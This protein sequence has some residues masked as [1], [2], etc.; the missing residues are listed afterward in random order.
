MTN[1][2]H[3]SSSTRVRRS[4]SRLD[5]DQNIL[6][7]RDGLQECENMAV[8]VMA[9]KQDLGA[10]V[11][12]VE[13]QKTDNW[14]LTA[15][16]IS[17]SYGQKL[18]IITD[19]E[20]STSKRARQEYAMDPHY[21]VIVHVECLNN[22]SCV[23]KVDRNTVV[24]IFGHV[25]EDGQTVSGL[26]GSSLADLI[27]KPGLEAAA[28]FS[29]D[30]NTTTELQH[31]FVRVLMVRGSKA[32]LETVQDHHQIYKIMEQSDSVSTYKI[33]ERPADHSTQY[34]HQQIVM[35]Q[36]NPV[37]RTAAES[38]YEKHPTVSS[39]YVLGNN[40]KPR[41]IRGEPV[42]LS[43]NSR[44]VLV[45]HGARDQSGEMKLA[46]LKSPE[47]AKIIQNTHKVSNKIKT[48]SVVA[49]DVGSDESFVE[50]LAKELHQ[51]GIETELHLRNSLV[52]VRHTGEKITQEF[53]VDGERWR[54]NDDS[55][56]VVATIDKNGDVII[57]SEA[58]SKGEAVF[59]NE[60]NFLG[61]KNIPGKQKGKSSQ[62]PE[63]PGRFIGEDV[64]SK[65]D[66]NNPDQVKSACDELEAMTWGLFYPKRDKPA[67]VDIN[68]NEHPEE[69]YV[70][71]K[72]VVNEMAEINEAEDIKE[73]LQ[74]CYEI[75]SGKDALR[76]I[77]HY[78]KTGETDIT[79]LKIGDW[80]FDVD[81]KTLYMIPAGKKL[82]NT[83]DKEEQRKTKEWIIEQ[84]GE[85]KEKYS[86]IQ[87]S[88]QNK[89]EYAD[90]VR[91]IFKGN[92]ISQNLS[93]DKA[94]FYASYF[95]AS[96]I[97][98][99]AR[100]FRTFPLT[101]M[102]LDL[103][104]SRPNDESV[105]NFL[106]ENHPMARQDSWTN[107][108]HRGFSGTAA[109]P[110]AHP[111]YE[112]KSKILKEVISLEF[113]LFTKWEQTVSDKDLL[114][115]FSDLVA[116]YI[117]ENVKPLK[118]NYQKFKDTLQD[119]SS[120]IP[121][122]EGEP[123]ASG[124]LSGHDD[125]YVTQRDVISASELENSFIHEAYFSRGSALLAEEIHTQVTKQFG[126][127]LAGMHVKKGSNRIENGEFI[128]Q[129]ESQF[130]DVE[131]VEFRT[132]LS[133][134]TQEFYK[135]LQENMDRSV[136][137]MEE[138]SLTSSHQGSKQVERV[139][140]AVGVL[141]LLLGMKG[142]IRAFEQGHVKDGVVG[143]LQ[144]AHGTAAIASSAIARTALSS[145]GRAAKAAVTIMRSPAMK[146]TM[147]AIPIMGIGIGVY[148]AVEDFKRHD[149]LG[150]IDGA[151]DIGMIALDVVELAQPELAPFIA[152]INV[153]LSV[154][155]MVVD[156]IYMGIKNELDSLP[157]DA[158]V[159][160]KI[161]A[162]FVGFGKGVFHFIIHVASLFYDWHYDEIEEGRRLVA[163]IS[164][165]RKYY[166]VTKETDGVTAIDFS[167][168]ASSWNGGG[169]DFCLADSGQSQLCMDYF[170]SSDESFGRLCWDIDAQGSTDIILGTGESHELE[171]TTLQ[172]K[173][174]LFIP[175]GSVTV[176]SGYK[177]AS[178]SRYG[179]YRGNR[180]SNRFF[181]VQNAGDTHMI[182]V[183]LSYY[184]KLYGE[185][186]DDKFFL[187]PQRTYVE[188]SG[189]KDTYLIPENGG[190]TIINNFDPSKAMDTLHFSVDYRD[191]SVSKSGD[192]VVLMYKSTHSVTIKNWFLGEL[193]RHMI[194]MSGDG[195]LFEI[196][197]TVVT[198]VQ[199]VATGINKMFQKLGETINAAD[200]LLRKVIGIVG[201]QSD[202]IIAGN[203]QNNLI[204]GGGGTDRLSGG[205]GED[206]YNIKGNSQSVLIENFSR[207]RKT[208]LAIIEANLHSFSLWVEG[209]DVKL[210]ADHDN[211]PIYVTLVNWFRSQEDRH[212]VIV[213][214]DLITFT[215]SD[216]IND[217]L[218]SNKF[219]KCIKLQSI[220]YS[221]SSSP[222]V[223]DLLADTA[224]NSLTEVR[225][226]TFNDVIKGNNE[227]NIFI[228][229]GGDDFM[230][231]RGGEDWY[232]I[233]PGGGEKIIN[234]Q[235]PDQVLDKLFLK[236]RY[237][238]LTAICELENIVILVNGK[239]TVVLQ[240]WFLSKVY[241]H[242]EIRTSDGV[243]AGLKTSICSCIDALIQPLIIDY[244]SSLHQT[245]PFCDLFCFKQSRRLLCG[246]KGKEI[247][248]KET[249]SVKE[250]FGSSG[251]DIMVG[252]KNDNLLDPY[253]GGAVM[254]G[255]EGEDTYVIK[256]GYGDNLWIDNFAE[257]Q[258]TD[259][260]LVD[261]DFIDGSQVVL[262]SS[263]ED[264]RGTIKTEGEELKFSLINYCLGD[265]HQHLDFLSS[266][267]V[268]FKLKSMNS[269]GDAPQ[270]QVEAFKVTLKQSEVDCRLDLSTQR[271][272]SNVQTAQ[273]CPSQSNYMIG[274]NQDNV[275][276]GGWK[277]DALD[278]G[279][280]DD[281]L[282]GGHGADILVGGMGDDTLYGED[283]K[284]TM[285]GGSGRDVFV[286]GPGPDLVDGGSGRDTVLYRGD[287][288]KGSG[289]YVNL[290]SGQGHYADAE[291][292]V[293]K[294]VE[295]VIGT[296]YS[297][298][299]VSGYESSLLKGSDGND[300]LVSTGGDYLVGGDGND[301]YMLAFNHGSVTI[302]NCAKD[303]AT[304]VLYFNS[305]SLPLFD[306]QFLPD[307]I[308]LTLFGPNQTAVKVG[309]KGW[310]GDASECG[311][312]KLVFRGVEISV[313]RI[314]TFYHAT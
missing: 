40:L 199:L 32:A 75:K 191:I 254:S 225:G 19:K 114:K 244:R 169:I 165:Y 138:H 183:M 89:Q 26:S 267:G 241:Q 190:K 266:D 120:L 214:K 291:G 308:I 159:L 206:I 78:A 289:V 64:Y 128:C 43:E 133:A 116:D 154:V 135:E 25:S 55:K 172:K 268:R 293:L 196:S 174:L 20:P 200:P 215:V 307:R 198:S 301:I 98:E 164:D 255:G 46:G 260:V 192:D 240:N 231:G 67:K 250:M 297:D 92:P 73:I 82:V 101:L 152:P 218:L 209:V 139:G 42:P 17:H 155:R 79:Y 24:R 72:K 243:T 263:T 123:Q 69:Q 94:F 238:S 103:I 261:M 9:K 274:N 290:L 84:N 130:A 49:C 45:G 204:D 39:L 269:S 310:R 251:F 148:N 219:L 305:H 44:L 1:I 182:E 230:Q 201:T 112:E 228:P 85:N 181:A 132:K 294:D 252:N 256:H 137:E 314:L 51:A 83:N 205:E 179:T 286:P 299:L 287:H 208:D 233:T 124:A 29:L 145:E 189:G 216:N 134:K 47:V 6:S 249:D 109:V 102:A 21:S 28:V 31:S 264:L 194:M 81:E 38:L 217:C 66:Q 270:F 245:D 110:R 37:V 76:L 235:S 50:T 195:V 184:Y 126:E 105:L 2:F 53:T 202:D 246:P 163:Q 80:I 127:N 129:L 150:Y 283:G 242:L 224:L 11:E 65:V 236:E 175:A 197:S 33:P 58:G 303:N 247:M 143:T 147:T 104:H 226:S 193:Y 176:V 300:I 86:N 313:D 211:T 149:T 88:I 302:D 312:L 158:S 146:G 96:V 223:V 70:I 227:H 12:H 276:I 54:H 161:G 271:N 57:R 157:K 282:I 136:Q 280:G 237:E 160:S 203:D 239:R 272:L 173:V 275:L 222:L 262:D 171:H 97:A 16:E 207:D 99:S 34:D 74:D 185:P 304:D 90:Y 288:E 306:H 108:R 36:D 77:R 3:F 212:L 213:T 8:C 100:N 167:A 107:S 170:V 27:L 309:L 278:G 95:A 281:A 292:D 311:H 220:D 153:A 118:R 61:P 257:D 141:G 62:W 7:L 117:T 186:G 121:T 91:D 41:L 142:S 259:T 14:L 166:V 122:D 56:K 87:G 279:E 210:K 253:T 187:G 30:G 151:F 229:G 125:G 177:D 284:D 52:Q 285:L 59:T 35:L 15:S 93:P 144:T 156:D 22:E 295:A 273:G 168:G 232:I 113:N 119:Q 13:K 115:R 162:A 258:K 277:D 106:F 23:P 296:I 265:Q 178:Y 71:M 188:G 18:L 298:I 60:R 131:P 234:N 68:N 10:L 248:M 111:K 4:V 221:T 63:E 180:A 5:I 140:T 48:T